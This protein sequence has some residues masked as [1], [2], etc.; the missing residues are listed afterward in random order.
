MQWTQVRRGRR[1]SGFGRKASGFGSRAPPPLAPSDERQFPSLGARP[2]RAATVA[3]RKSSAG[4]SSARKS[5]A[6]PAGSFLET[7]VAENPRPKPKAV[8][9][10]VPIGWLRMRCDG[11][12]TEHP[13]SVKVR[14]DGE[15]A[16]RKK[17]TV[18]AINR[19]L[20]MRQQE[21]DVQNELLGEMSPYYG[22]WDITGP[23]GTSDAEY[24]EDDEPEN[25][26]SEDS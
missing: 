18:E 6:A 16:R 9:P 15:E 22:A 14:R 7:L 1:A 19:M 25:Y 5:A 8:E 3:A 20:R 26:S 11:S 4:K 23:P 21:R 10:E 13:D 17:T 2:G 12:R 24:S